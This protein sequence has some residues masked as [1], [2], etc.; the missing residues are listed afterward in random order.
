MRNS[1]LVLALCLILIAPAASAQS[2]PIQDI[3][4][5][6]LASN[7]VSRVRRAV[8]VGPFVGAMP[9]IPGTGEV[10]G[11]LS[12][13]LSLSLFKVPIIPDSDTIKRIVLERAQARLKAVLEAAALRGEKPTEDEVATLGREIF[14]QVLAEFL[15][16]RAPRLWEKPRFHMHLEAARLF[17]TGSWQSRTTLAV[18][19][20]RVS[21]GPTLLVDFHDGA[22]LF[23]GPE[24]TVQLLPG[25]G[26]RSPIVDLFVRVDFAVTDDARENLTS[27]GGRFV[28]D[29]I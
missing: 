9:V 20:W 28:L 25:K 8:A 4:V 1:S 17:R 14:E 10:D 21:L 22:D 26:P 13:G 5:G 29:L 6:K 24:M 15:A 27:F 3:P 12:F 16:E 23:L 19:V 11:A 7:T 18:G 2:I